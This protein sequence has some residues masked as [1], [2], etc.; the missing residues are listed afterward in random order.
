MRSTTLMAQ[1]AAADFKAAAIVAHEQLVPGSG[2]GFGRYLPVEFREMGL[3]MHSAAAEFAG[4]AKAA[5]VP[6]TAA[7]W[8]TTMAALQ[9]ISNQWRACHS[10]LRV[11]LTLIATTSV[12][13]SSPK[14]LCRRPADQGHPG[15][16]SVVRMETVMQTRDMSFGMT[17]A[18][19]A[20]VVFAMPATAQKGTG[21]RTGVAQQTVKPPI[22]VLA[23]TIK[24]TK[25]G[26]CERTTG[27]SAEGVHLIVEAKD[28]RTINLHL[29]P[30]AA[31]DDA[32]EQLSA[33]KQIT[34]EA[35][36]TNIMPTDAYVAKS[37]TVGETTFQLRDDN[38]RP[39][40]AIAAQGGRGAE[41]GAGMGAGGPPSQGRGSRGGSCY[42]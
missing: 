18:F 21:E 5:P 39:K 28:G 30:T 36:R 9:A 3:T 20:M 11:E 22:E 42:W 4:V 34:F 40:W 24:D 12:R 27:R 14:L 13:R 17:M 10:A 6:P 32:L 8:K 29:G 19:L 33:G 41:R 1:L 7:D 35:F 16:G 25:I 26:P 31:L 38:L 2:A 15:A 37:L 23:G